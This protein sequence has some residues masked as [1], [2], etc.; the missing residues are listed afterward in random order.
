[1]LVIRFARTGKKH[2]A[3]Y[4]IVVADKRSAVG[5]KFIEIVGNYDPHAKK[6]SLDK[7]KIGEYLKNGAQPSNSVAKILKSEKVELPKWVKIAEKNKAPKK[8]EEP[9]AEAPKTEEAPSEEGE[10]APVEAAE[11]PTE[12]EKPAEEPESDSEKTE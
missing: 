9:K 10:V 5:A 1:L 3:Y 7:E 6:V 11:V 8:V 12:E 2:Q 4:R